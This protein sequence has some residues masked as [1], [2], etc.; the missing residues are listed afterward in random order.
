MKLSGHL[1][2]TLDIG[3]V[4]HKHETVNLEKTKPHSYNERERERGHR[5]AAG[6]E[7]SRM[8]KGEEDGRRTGGGGRASESRTSSK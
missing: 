4:N 1:I 6:Q 2:H 5:I 7:G 3:R 8:M